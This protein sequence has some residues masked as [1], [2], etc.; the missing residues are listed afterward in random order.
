MILIV[1]LSMIIDFLWQYYLP[2][3]PVFCSYLKPLLFITTCLIFM[4]FESSNHK[5]M[6]LLFGISVIY[7]LLFS[8]IYFLRTIIF[9][10]LY[11]IIRYWKKH[12]NF[13]FLSFL[14]IIIIS[15]IGFLTLQYT[16]LLGIG[17][18]TYSLSFLVFQILHSCLLNVLYSIILYSFLGLK[19]RSV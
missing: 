13:T 2:Y 10:I 16:L 18:I 12:W 17:M 6:K 8:K 4:A 3:F 14:F 7:D 9:L 11:Q 19:K 15:L 1:L 5:K